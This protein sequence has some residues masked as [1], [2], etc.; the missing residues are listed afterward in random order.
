[1]LDMALEPKRC[2]SRFLLIEYVFEMAYCCF[3]IIVY[4]NKNAMKGIAGAVVIRTAID[5][6][7]VESQSAYRRSV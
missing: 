1:M 3:D 5:V 2:R 6:Q 7:N 4:E